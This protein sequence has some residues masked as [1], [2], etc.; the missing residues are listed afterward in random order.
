MILDALQSALAQGFR[1]IGQ[2][3][4]HSRD[5]AFLLCHLADREQVARGDFSG[6]T[7]YDKPTE[8]IELSRY[9][10]D[11]H[12]RF[13]KGEVSLKSAWYFELPDLASLRETLDHFYPAALGLWLARQEGRLRVQHLRDKLARQTGMYRHAGKISDAGA[14]ELVRET[15]GPANQCAKKILWQLDAE[16][17]LDD[18]EASRF[19]GILDGQSEPSANPLLCQEACNHFVAQC[20]LKTKEE[21]EATP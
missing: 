8:A 17:P 13:T 3:A 7:R 5:G 14:Q 11:G 21:F 12:F 10:A 20:R 16:T 9:A 15:C 1:Q 6:L 4:I 19:S 2:I 18:N